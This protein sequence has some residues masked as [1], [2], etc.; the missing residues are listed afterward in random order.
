LHRKVITEVL[1]KKSLGLSY[2]RDWR[3]LRL[4]RILVFGG[5]IHGEYKK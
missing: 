3:G 4:F 1:L 2:V 5:R